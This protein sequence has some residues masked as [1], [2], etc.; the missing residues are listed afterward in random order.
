MAT[1][2]P[3]FQDIL[4]AATQLGGEAGKGKDTQVKF[5]L[6]TIEG[7]YHNILDLNHNKHG[8]DVDDATK[9]AEVYVKAQQGAVVF[10]AKAPNQRKLISCVRTG[11][12]L[13]GWPKGG[14]GEPIAT[15]NNLMSKRAALRK[16]PA[17]AKLLNDAANTLLAYA[18]AQLKLD[19]LIDDAGLEEFLFKP[20][21]DD[22]TAEE[23]IA[24]T[25]KKLD[26]LIDGSASHGTAQAKTAH[27]LNARDSLRKELADIAK[28]KAPVAGQPVKV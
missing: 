9:L 4:D 8:T 3:T 11:I 21:Q 24:N 13:G 2:T 22:L 26:K 17:Q 27:V 12:K 18:R 16:I 6:K 15:V 23:I 5:L 19:R 14:N 25:V 1:N 7:G 28:A 20:T 10:D